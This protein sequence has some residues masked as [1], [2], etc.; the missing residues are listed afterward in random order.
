VVAGAGPL[1]NL[2]HQEVVAPEAL[3]R[4]MIVRLDGTR[5][6]DDLARDVAADRPALSAAEARELARVTLDLLAASGLLVA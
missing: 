1:T 6:L 3:V 4:A 5:A 2:W